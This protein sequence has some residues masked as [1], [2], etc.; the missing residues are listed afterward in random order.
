MDIQKLSDIMTPN[1]IGVTPVTPIFETLMLMSSKHISCVVVMEKGQP[2]GIVTERNV[3]RLLARGWYDFHDDPVQEIMSSPLVT[4]SQET[5]IFEA[6]DLLKSHGLRHLVVV[7]DNRRPVGLVTQSNIVEHLTAESFVE[8]KRVSQ[9]M[10]RVVCSVG[11]EAPLPQ[12]LKDMSS[13]SVSCIVVLEERRPIGIITERDVSHLPVDHPDYAHLSVADVMSTGLTT[14]QTDTPIADAV[15][16]MREKR[17]RHMIVVDGDGLIMG[18]ATQS[19]IVRGLEG[20]Y[21]KKIS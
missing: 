4:A 14:V 16:I 6:Y 9:V 7:D 18:L 8:I 19:D 1:I 5:D 20:R 13:K 10:T 2:A 15:R 3:V 11:R 17:L 21:I 12:A